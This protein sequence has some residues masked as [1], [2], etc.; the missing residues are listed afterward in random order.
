MRTLVVEGGIPVIFLL[1]LALA[2]LASALSFA[3][4][5]SLRGER[6]L[7]HA[8]HAILAATFVG[9]ALDVGATLHHAGAEMTHDRRIQMVV[10]GI[11]ESM[12]PAIVGLGALV[13]V[14]IL[15]A[16]GHA[17]LSRAD[18]D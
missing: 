12:A 2:T 8:V 4:R 3:A 9:V 13:V 14:S 10:V 11:G 7:R 17:R 15:R 5:P 6:A 18:E 1:V 16:I